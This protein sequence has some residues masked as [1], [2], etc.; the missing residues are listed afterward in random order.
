LLVACGG[1]KPQPSAVKET[2]VA[3]PDEHPS[4]I[5]V[6]KEQPA[7]D[8]YQA[9]AEKN[10]DAPVPYVRDERSSRLDLPAPKAR[11]K[12]AWRAPLALGDAPPIH[13]SFVLAAGNRAVVMGTESWVLFDTKGVRIAGHEM[14][15]PNIRIDRASGA[16]VPDDTRAPDLPPDS[17]VAAHDGLVVMVKNGGVYIGER[18]IEGTFEPFDLAIDDKGNANVLVKQKDDLAIWTVPIAPNAAIGRHKIGAKRRSI[19]P[20]VLGSKLRV[21]VLDTGVAAFALDGKKLW[22][23]KGV[24]TGGV[25]ITNDD[26]VLIADGNRVVSVDHK[27]K[28]L[29]IWSAPDLTLVTPPILNAGGLLLVASGTFLHGV[30]F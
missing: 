7:P 1:S 22:E 5:V 30:A 24:P 2:K 26:H 23:Q 28:K 29:E 3:P 17:K 4:S 15:A 16:V 11:G 19:G 8:P 12:E 9:S 21:V 20:P 14:E 27:G 13:A 25:S 6:V 10:V 18:A